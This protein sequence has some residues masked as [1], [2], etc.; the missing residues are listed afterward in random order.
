[1]RKQIVRHKEKKAAAAAALDM[2]TTK[3]E[4]DADFN[5]S[6]IKTDVNNKPMYPTPG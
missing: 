2:G 4:E 6:K 3:K 5:F 1:M